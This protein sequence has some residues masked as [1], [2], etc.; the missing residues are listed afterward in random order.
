MTRGSLILPS[1]RPITR[2]LLV[3][4]QLL[5]RWVLSQARNINIAKPD[6]EML[7]HSAGG[8]EIDIFTQKIHLILMLLFK[9]EALVYLP[10]LACLF[11]ALCLNR[12][13][14]LPSRDRRTCANEEK[15]ITGTSKVPATSHKHSAIYYKINVPGALGVCLGL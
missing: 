12:K 14:R 15:V 13:F 8:H 2:R 3:E 4:R 6:K 9:K 1:E 10:S 11:L 5:K 7:C